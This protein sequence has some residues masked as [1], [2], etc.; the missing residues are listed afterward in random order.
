[1][2]DEKTCH[3]TPANFSLSSYGV[4]ENTNNSSIETPTSLNMDDHDTLAISNGQ[5]A[6]VRNNGIASGNKS[7]HF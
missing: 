4:L 2:D 1:M 7:I 6:S 3:I 5:L